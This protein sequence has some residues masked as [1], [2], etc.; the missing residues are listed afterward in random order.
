MS[1]FDLVPY[2]TI[3]KEISMLHSMDGGRLDNTKQFLWSIPHEISES[4][5]L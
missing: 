4:G 2:E 1:R 5:T 3:I